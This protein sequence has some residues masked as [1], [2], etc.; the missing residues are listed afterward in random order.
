[1]WLCLV[2]CTRLIRTQITVCSASFHLFLPEFD[3]L[4]LRPQLIH[5]SLKYQGVERPDLLGL[6]CRLR[7]D[8]GMTFPS[9][10]LTL[11]HWMGSRVQSIVGCFPELYF[12][13]FSVVQ[14]LVGLRKKFI[15]NFTFSTS[16]CA[17]SFNNNNNNNMP[18]STLSNAFSKFK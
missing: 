7:F 1:M 10:C 2:C 6:S 4:E 8:C 9:L 11:E 15:I 14:V 3:T 17:A 5:W 18:W 13:Q 12:L 16:A